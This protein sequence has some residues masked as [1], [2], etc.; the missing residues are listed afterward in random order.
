VELDHQKIDDY[1]FEGGNLTDLLDLLEMYNTKPLGIFGL[2]DITLC[3]EREFKTKA[4]RTFEKM[5]DYCYRV[6]CNYIMMTP[7][8]MA[9]DDLKAIP[10]WRR[11]NKTIERLKFIIKH[12]YDQDIAIGLE[13]SSDSGSSIEQ[14]EELIE[15]FR[16]LEDKENFSCII[17]AFHLKKADINISDLNNELV[18]RIG[19]IQLSDTKEI[20]QNFKGG[21]KELKRAIPTETGCS[22]ELISF[23]QRIFYKKPFSLEFPINLEITR[24]K[25]LSKNIFSVFKK[26]RT[27]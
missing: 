24:L 5:M 13:F 17:D 23:F 1:L 27:F 12:A 14:L 18:E 19:L 11:I 9:I 4:L 10:K 20:R 26:A 8:K 21:E 6:H 15:I 16:Q 25:D 7:S 22:F 2:K 3:S